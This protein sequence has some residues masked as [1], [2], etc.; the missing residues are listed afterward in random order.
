M[1]NEGLFYSR[2]I[3]RSPQGRVQSSGY[4]DAPD[5]TR[6]LGAMKLSGKTRSGWSLGVLHAL[7]GQ[8]EALLATSAGPAGDQVVEPRAQYGMARFSKD[9]REGKSAVG[10][11][12]TWTPAATPW[13]P[14]HSRSHSGAY[15][16]GI[17][18]PPP[19]RR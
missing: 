7:T 15:T 2:R 13:R 1:A 14:A 6:I 18:R 11:I 9:F 10:M 5:R 17:G 16:G 4:F 12:S 3:G 8:E 19:L